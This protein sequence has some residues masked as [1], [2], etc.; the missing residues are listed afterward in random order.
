MIRVMLHNPETGTTTTGGIELIS[1]WRDSKDLLWVDLYAEDPATELA[2]LGKEFGIHK[3]AVQDAQRDRHPPK[4]EEFEG[5]YFLLLKGLSKASMGIN[6]E[7]IQIAML[8]GERFLITRHS[9]ESRSIEQLWALCLSD[10]RVFHKGLA[11]L[12][13]RLGRMVVNRYLDLLFNIEANL[14]TI[15]QDLLLQDPSNDQLGMLTTYKTRLRIMLRTFNYHEQIFNQLRHNKAVTVDDLLEHE[16]TDTYEQLERAASLANLYYDL[17]DDLIN[18]SISMASHRLNGIMKVLTIVTAIFVPLGFLAG[19]YG[20]N[21]E[22]IPEL[23]FEYGY[24][25]LLGLMATVVVALLTL[26]RIKRWL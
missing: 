3:L 5:Y 16:F 14:D 23:H 18:S 10:G 11:G 26:F 19:L 2:F 6:F 12:T 22:N 24:Y 15:E 8:V 4:F 21:F 7:T 13:P 9:S 17:S 20:M 25:V 1:P